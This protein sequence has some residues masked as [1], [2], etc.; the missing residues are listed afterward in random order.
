MRCERDK[1]RKTNEWKRTG[2]FH[3]PV[4]RKEVLNEWKR[5]GVFHIV[6]LTAQ[7]NEWKRTAVFHR[8]CSQQRRMSGHRVMLTAKM[9]KWK[10]TKV[11][12]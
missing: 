2:V 12:W 10:R 9:N 5:T 6:M 7:T 11:L 3:R 1:A 8:V 4:L